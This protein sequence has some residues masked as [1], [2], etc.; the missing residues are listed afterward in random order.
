MLPQGQNCHISQSL[1]GHLILTKN[2]KNMPQH[3]RNYILLQ[4]WYNASICLKNSRKCGMRRNRDGDL[5]VLLSTRKNSA[6]ACSSF[7]LLEKSRSINR[8]SVNIDLFLFPHPSEKYSDIKLRKSLTPTC[9]THTH[10]NMRQIWYSL[11]KQPLWPSI[12]TETG[13]IFQPLW[14]KS[15]HAATWVQ[16]LCA[17]L[18]PRGC[19]CPREGLL[20]NVIKRV[21]EGKALFGKHREPFPEQQAW[22]INHSTLI[23]AYSQM[24][25]SEHIQHQAAVL[26]T[27]LCFIFLQEYTTVTPWPFHWCVPLTYIWFQNHWQPG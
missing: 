4:W 5:L 13:T 18:N 9:Y 24:Q 2:I 11:V 19:G 7:I 20:E 16:A 27:P 25:P 14:M 12:L 8:I 21:T 6:F 10:T 3:T 23:R 1:W 22:G 15:V 17:T 26:K